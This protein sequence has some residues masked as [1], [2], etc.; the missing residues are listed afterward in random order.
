MTKVVAMAT[1]GGL[2][3]TY[4]NNRESDKAI[5]MTKKTKPKPANQ[6]A[7]H[8][9]QDKCENQYSRGKTR[10]GLE[11]GTPFLTFKVRDSIKWQLWVTPT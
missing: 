8:W 4:E 1:T 7:T 6:G 2:I 10:V 9:Q 3:L 5:T 11:F